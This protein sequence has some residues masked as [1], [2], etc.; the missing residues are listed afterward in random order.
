LTHNTAAGIPVITQSDRGTENNGIAN[1][2]TLIRQT[3]DPTL[4]GTLQHCFTIGHNN[5]LSEA[6]WSVFRRDF[7]PG[8]ED[9]LEL[10]V[11]QGW[12][13]PDDYLEKYVLIFSLII[14]YLTSLRN[15]I[16]VV[17]YSM[18]AS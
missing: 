15:I 17:G 18:V 11:M 10:R 14:A 5:I 13:N 12:Y 6:K 9:I 7:A 8:F 1:V 3:L 2:Q 4:N 16:S